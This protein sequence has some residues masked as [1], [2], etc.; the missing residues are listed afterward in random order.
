MKQKDLAIIIAACVFAGVLS[1]LLARVV[2]ATPKSRQQ[3]VEVVEAISTDFTLPD[4][5][6]FNINSINPTQL[7]RIADN[8]NAAPFNG[9]N[10]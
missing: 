8:S 3:K 9:T 7:I 10:Q 6:Y 1:V 5:K 4:A 2:F